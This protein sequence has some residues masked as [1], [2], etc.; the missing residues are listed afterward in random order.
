MLSI[1]SSKKRDLGAEG[2]WV[3]P[4]GSGEMVKEGITTK[5]G[6]EDR[7]IGAVKTGHPNRAGGLADEESGAD[8]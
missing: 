7:P 2:H 6:L 3:Q 1:Q 5:L 4:R 8:R